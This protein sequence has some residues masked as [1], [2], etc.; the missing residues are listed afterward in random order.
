MPTWTERMR[1]I[2][3]RWRLGSILYCISLFNVEQHF[4]D[5]R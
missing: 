1:D 3:S 4:R 5:E 2:V